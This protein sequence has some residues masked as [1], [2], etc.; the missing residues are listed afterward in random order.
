MPRQSRALA[1]SGVYHVMMRGVNRDVIFFADD[2]YQR[3]LQALKRAKDASECQV[4]AY[5][6]M[7]NHV[8]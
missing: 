1:E 3:F 4:L 2:A 5:S 8:H 6:L 7:S